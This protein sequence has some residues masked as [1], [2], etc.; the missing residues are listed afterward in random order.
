MLIVLLFCCFGRS[1]ALLCSASL[2]Q[3]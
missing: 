2:G 1:S 3:W